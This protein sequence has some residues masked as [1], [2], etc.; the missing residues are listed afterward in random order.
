MELVGMSPP[1]QIMMGT[2]DRTRTDLIRQLNVPGISSPDIIRIRKQLSDLGVQ[3]GVTNIINSNPPEAA[4][5]LGTIYDAVDT[6]LGGWL[7]GGVPL[8]SSV[9]GTGF[10]QNYPVATGGGGG[11][12]VI[13]N[14][15]T[16]MP[17]PGPGPGG[18]GD[19]GPYPVMKRV[20]GQY[21]WVYPKRRRRKMFFTQGDAAQLSSLLS[22]AGKGEIAK[23]WIATSKR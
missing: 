4:V 12:G 14:T 20:C 9:P 7:P 3:G 21:K 16:Q 23:A 13:I 18:G 15:P 1:G 22:I 5:D 2:N 6:V 11:G 17:A 10:G 19:C 8:G